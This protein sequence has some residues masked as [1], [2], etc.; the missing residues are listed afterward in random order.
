MEP[1][2]ALLA[3]LAGLGA[4][5]VIIYGIAN[6]VLR[7]LNLTQHRKRWAIS[8]SGILTLLT[9]AST[10]YTTG[11]LLLV[12]YQIGIPAPDVTA[13]RIFAGPNQYPPEEFAAYGILAF[14]SR[15]S[16][17]DRARHLMICNAY[18]TSLPHTFELTIA[19]AEQMVT[20]WPV[21]SDSDASRLNRAPR[22]GICEIAVDNYGLVI[23]QQALKDAETAGVNTT[24]SGPFLFAWSPSTDKGKQDALV[25][26]SDLS[27]V[28]TYEHAHEILLEWSRDI[29]QDPQLWSNGWDVERLRRKIRHWVDKYGPKALAVIGVKG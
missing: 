14:R 19:R 26:V 7:A 9:A 28:T 17:Y 29:E 11:D 8:A 16:P 27:D 22:N 4:V 20:V 10:Y 18:V 3:F 12:K 23:A 25:L 24:D 15:P 21:D 5:C 1:L 13:S 2:L 6:G